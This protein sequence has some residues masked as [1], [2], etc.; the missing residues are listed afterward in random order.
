MFKNK[1]VYV[2]FKSFLLTTLFSLTGIVGIGVVNATTIDYESCDE[3]V[4]AAVKSKYEIYGVLNRVK[5]SSAYEWTDHISMMSAN[6]HFVYCTEKGIR[7][8]NT[9]TPSYVSSNESVENSLLAKVLAYGYNA[10]E[11]STA[12]TT[13]RVA[14]QVLVHFAAKEIADGTTAWRTLSKSQRF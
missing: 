1:K 6:G 9:T 5:S 12:C 10:E 3:S 2:F 13:S 8:L 14:T 11:T 4:I 7:P